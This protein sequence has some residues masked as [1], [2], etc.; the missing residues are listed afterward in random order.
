MTTRINRRNF[1]KR[2]TVLSAGLAAGASC[3]TRAGGRV[4]PFP[5]AAFPLQWGCD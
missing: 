5:Q 4:F 3:R 1:L 2:T